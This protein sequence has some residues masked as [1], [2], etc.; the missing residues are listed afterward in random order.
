MN[1]ELLKTH[2]F[3]FKLKLNNN[4]TK[5]KADF[6]ERHESILYYNSYGTDKILAMN[7]EEMYEYLSQL[8]AMLIWGNKKYYIDK[9]I[10]DNGLEKLKKQL[11]SLVW[12]S[13]DI[14]IRW[15]D[16]RKEIT[17]L[18][19]AMISEILCKTHPN[20]FILWNRRAYAALEYLGVAGLPKYDYQFSGKKYK[21]LCAVA[22]EIA[23]EMQKAGLEDVSLLAVDYFIW[24]ELQ[25]VDNLSDIYKT[26]KDVP[27]IEEIKDKKTTEFIHNEVR[28]K[29]SNIGDWLGFKAKTE[30]KVAEGSRVD[31]YWE[32]T[33]GNMGRVIYVFEVQTSGSI[34]SLLMNLLK[35]LNNPAVQGVVA[36]SDENQLIKI[37]NQAQH[38]PN[39]RDKLKYWDYQEV[40]KVHESLSFVNESINK[41]QLVPQGF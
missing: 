27:V 32:A 20:D 16:F 41:L 37:K 24:D 35:T 38:I 13:Q 31:A 40:L 14:E 11:N 8:W 1:N 26:K 36:V 25:V 12:G 9:V 28:D 19:P 22:K 7:E 29:I 18:G 15:N 2:I 4:Q 30:Q 33:I 23:G 5:T 6:K 34:D 17:G 10:A 39:L 21:D 3:N